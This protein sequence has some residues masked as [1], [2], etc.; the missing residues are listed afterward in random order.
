GAQQIA[1]KLPPLLEAVRREGRR[2][3][4]ICDAMHGNTESTRNGY[5]TRRFENIRSEIEQAFDLH[6]AAGTRLGGVHLELTGE[7]VTECLGG[8]RELTELDLQRA[9]R[10]TVDPRLNYEQALEIAMLIVRKRGAIAA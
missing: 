1:E 7:N 9:Y 2:V 10:T 3:L 6:A 5:K 8:A 4:W